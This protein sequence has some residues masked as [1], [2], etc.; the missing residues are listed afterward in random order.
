MADERACDAPSY[1][2][3]PSQKNVSRSNVLFL[4]ALQTLQT[5]IECETVFCFII[6]IQ[7][8]VIHNPSLINE[9]S[10]YFVLPVH[11]SFMHVESL[12]H[13]PY[14]SS[15]TLHYVLSHNYCP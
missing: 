4:G 13:V 7:N 1:C 8:E 9:F 15:S 12:Q 2:S 6:T 14:Y 11:K 3:I 5:T 10:L